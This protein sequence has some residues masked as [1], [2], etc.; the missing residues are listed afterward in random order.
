MFSS[1]DYNS[2]IFQNKKNFYKNRDSTPL[3]MNFNILPYFHQM[4]IINAF[5][6][7]LHIKKKFYKKIE[8]IPPE[9]EFYAFK[10]IFQHKK[11]LQK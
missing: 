5:E 9:N 7:I 4:T 6:H 2:Y 8:S 11:F 3:K 1:K 10:H